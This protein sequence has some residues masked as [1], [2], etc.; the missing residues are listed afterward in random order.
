MLVVQFCVD[1]K[2][3]HRKIGHSVLYVEQTVSL[4]SLLQFKIIRH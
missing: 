1:K 2:Q 3:K 4:E